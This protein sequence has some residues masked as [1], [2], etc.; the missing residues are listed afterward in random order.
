MYS[1]KVTANKIRDS[2]AE[3][4]P[5]AQ[6]FQSALAFLRLDKD[7]EWLVA[8]YNEV[9]RGQIHTLKVLLQNNMQLVDLMARVMVKDDTCVQIINE[10]YAIC[11][12]NANHAAKTT[13]YERTLEEL[14]LTAMRLATLLHFNLVGASL[15]CFWKDRLGSSS[16]K[17]I[18]TIDRILWETHPPNTLRKPLLDNDGAEDAF[19]AAIAHDLLARHWINTNAPHANKLFETEV[20]C[21]LQNLGQFDVSQHDASRWDTLQKRRGAAISAVYVISAQRTDLFGE[22]GA[23]GY[24]DRRAFVDA[25]CTGDLEEVIARIKGVTLAEPTTADR[26]DK[27]AATLQAAAAAAEQQV[28]ASTALTPVPVP[29]H[30]QSQEPQQSPEMVSP[31]RDACPSD[32]K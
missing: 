25:L 8:Y 7:D 12:E 13:V 14:R 27:V 31:P 28:P 9:C 5:T 4:A 16:V 10:V 22:G 30:R 20:L 17:L 2:L 19:I 32:A 1:T 15:A 3:N 21:R 11:R 18:A 6:Y 29:D 24:S 23:T 26:V